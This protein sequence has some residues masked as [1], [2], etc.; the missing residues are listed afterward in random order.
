M[1]AQAPYPNPF[2]GKYW[3][4]PDQHLPHNQRPQNWGKSRSRCDQTL[5]QKQRPQN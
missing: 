2:S 4:S 5:P 3:C 1:D